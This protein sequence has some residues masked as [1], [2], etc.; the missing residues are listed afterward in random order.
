M[1]LTVRQTGTSITTM[2]FNM[3]EL[4]QSVSQR[5]IRNQAFI[6]ARFGVMFILMSIRQD[7]L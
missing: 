5:I 3:V 7:V 2:S 1:A 6:N 4:M